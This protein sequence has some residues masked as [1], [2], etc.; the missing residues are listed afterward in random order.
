MPVVIVGADHGSEF[1]AAKTLQQILNPIVGENNQLTIVVG[2]RCLG[3]A[4]Q[5]IDL[6]LLGSFG[7]GITFTGHNGEARGLKPEET[8]RPIL[9]IWSAILNV[10]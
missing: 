10:S 8:E 6:L 7:R 3:E 9:N 2:A 1:D 5:D 4:V